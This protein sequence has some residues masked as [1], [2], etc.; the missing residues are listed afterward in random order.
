[1]QFKEVIPHTKAIATSMI[2]FGRF[3]MLILFSYIEQ[4]KSYIIFKKKYYNFYCLC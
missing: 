1:M 2:W 4:P 3:V